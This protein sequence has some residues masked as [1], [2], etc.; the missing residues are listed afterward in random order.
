M[1]SPSPPSV[2]PPSPTQAAAPVGKDQKDQPRDEKIQRQVR[3]VHLA[4]YINNLHYKTLGATS[5]V[6]DRR[7]AVKRLE[8]FLLSFLFLPPVFTVE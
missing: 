8:M 5:L 2:H 3:V 6:G 4:F 1:D 7:T